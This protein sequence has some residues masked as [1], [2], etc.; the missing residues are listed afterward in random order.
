[1]KEYYSLEKSATVLARLSSM[2][3]TQDGGG[4]LLEFSIH[5]SSQR[6]SILTFILKMSN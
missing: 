5:H 3:I 1:M 2:T 4:D 6:Y